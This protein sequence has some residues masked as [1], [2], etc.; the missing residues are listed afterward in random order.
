MFSDVVIMLP[1]IIVRD[2]D[3]LQRILF[4]AVR[5]M[6]EVKPFRLVFWL[7]KLPRVE[8]DDRERLKEMIGMQVAEGGFGP[9]VRP[10]DIVSCARTAQPL[11]SMGRLLW[12][13]AM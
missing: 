6:C 4:R 11:G 10:P 13:D 3:F 5:N 7:G 12:R 9:L 1:D 2:A 8:E